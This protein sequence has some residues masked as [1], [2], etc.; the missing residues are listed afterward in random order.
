VNNASPLD[1]EEKNA[2]DEDSQ[3]FFLGARIFSLISDPSIEPPRWRAS[4][5]ASLMRCL[6]SQSRARCR[7]PAR[8]R[9]RVA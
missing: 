4:L 6:A 5:F 8:E 7:A 2:L 1:R 9:W 3:E